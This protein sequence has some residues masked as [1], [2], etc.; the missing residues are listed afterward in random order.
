[1]APTGWNAATRGKSVR[2]AARIGTK[3]T[4]T[5]SALVCRIRLRPARATAAANR[6]ERP[7]VQ[8]P[9]E[10]DVQ[11]HVLASDEEPQTDEEDLENDGS[12]ECPCQG[13]V[14]VPRTADHLRTSIR[15]IR[16]SYDA[17]P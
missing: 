15:I 17:A 6:I 10:V 11:H 9:A 16:P 12:H 7:E 13:D 14:S 5:A 2:T 8:E 3:N 4:K 1:M